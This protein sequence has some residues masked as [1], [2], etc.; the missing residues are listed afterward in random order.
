M[1]V[2]ERDFLINVS[3]IQKRGGR[4]NFSNWV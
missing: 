3:Q 2:A 4:A 1:S